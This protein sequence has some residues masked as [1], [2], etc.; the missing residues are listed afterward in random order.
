MEDQDKCF[1]CYDSSNVLI[2]SP[3][4]CLTLKCHRSCMLTWINNYGHI[5]C[6]V[7]RELYKV[8]EQ[9]KWDMWFILH[10]MV[11]PFMIRPLCETTFG[12]TVIHIILP[13]S[14][15]GIIAGLA[16]YIITT[17]YFQKKILVCLQKLAV[18]MYH[19]STYI[20]RTI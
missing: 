16:T 20:E 4:I 18:A 2:S 5:Y 19:M 11:F 7:C 10:M 9:R 14:S 8:R 1:I 12:K 17:P 6:N 13:V 3:C 15:T